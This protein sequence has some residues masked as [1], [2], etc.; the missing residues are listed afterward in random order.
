MKIAYNLFIVFVLFA[1]PIYSQKLDSIVVNY[2]DFYDLTVID[3]DCLSFESLLKD[4][5]FE[6]TICNR[7]EINKIYRLVKAL[8]KDSTL[9]SIDTRLKMKIY[10]QRDGLNEI[11]M[12]LHTVYKDGNSYCFSKRLF[13]Y[14]EKLKAKY[15]RKK[16][17]G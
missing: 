8:H 7:R 4:E 10:S 3:I 12:G 6:F 13:V 5:L 1:F 14:I 11:C 15:S 17:A 9:S 2:I 16:R